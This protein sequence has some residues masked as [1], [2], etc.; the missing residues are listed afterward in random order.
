MQYVRAH[1][2]GTTVP[3]SPREAITAGYLALPLERMTLSKYERVNAVQS[4]NGLLVKDLPNQGAVVWCTAALRLRGM[5]GGLRTYVF[6]G[7]P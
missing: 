2:G 7:H 5:G 3:R 4:S 6:P 1:T